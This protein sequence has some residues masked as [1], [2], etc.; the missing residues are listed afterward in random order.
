MKKILLT[1]LVLLITASYGFAAT[2][3]NQYKNYNSYKSNQT[4]KW[5]NQ[6][7]ANMYE[8]GW[9]EPE[10]MKFKNEK[11]R[12]SYEHEKWANYEY[13]YEEDAEEY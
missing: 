2:N 13:D 3:S 4:Q 8:Y 12:Q 6:E 10:Y 11:D 9:D 5:K 1:L 7:Q